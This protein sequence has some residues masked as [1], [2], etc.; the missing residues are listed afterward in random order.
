V[1]LTLSHR[2][3]SEAKERRRQPRTCF[4]AE[5]LVLD[6][7]SG[8]VLQVLVASDLS[9][10]GIRVE[11]HP[12]LALGAEL[13]L[14]F[15]AVGEPEPIHL[16][17]EAAR[18]D[19]NLGWLLCFIEPDRSTQMRIHRLMRKLPAAETYGSP[20]EDTVQG[21]SFARIQ[22]KAVLG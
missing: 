12:N 22:P 19:G 1:D 20:P 7:R 18:D 6:G 9:V 3:K 10:E 8:R 13:D 17:A 14:A 11:P 16:R 15:L 4:D 2:S 5:I 21:I